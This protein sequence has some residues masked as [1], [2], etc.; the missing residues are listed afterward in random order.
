[1]CILHDPYTHEANWSGIS[2]LCSSA[3]GDHSTN[4]RSGMDSEAWMDGVNPEV[5]EGGGKCNFC[6]GVVLVVWRVDRE[7]FC[8][9]R[10]LAF[11]TCTGERYAKGEMV[12]GWDMGKVV[13]GEKMVGQRIR[14]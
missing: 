10:D 9:R 14:F 6:P 5:D 11:R 2:L 4:G 7:R 1:M 12:L 13:G 8:R 3:A